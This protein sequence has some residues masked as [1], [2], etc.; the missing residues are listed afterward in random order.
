MRAR[1]FILSSEP[2]PW[3]V[4]SVFVAWRYLWLS[5]V[6]SHS[7]NKHVIVGLCMASLPAVGQCGKVP[8]V[9]FSAQCPFPSDGYLFSRTHNY[10]CVKFAASQRNC[11]FL[12]INFFV[13]LRSPFFAVTCFAR[14]ETCF[15]FA[16][17][18]VFYHFSLSRLTNVANY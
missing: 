16:S 12:L 14:S 9:F 5:H 13:T 1:V 7:S 17:Q 3:L 8:C 10:V 2:Q 4:H 11:V 6:M 18:L 15:F